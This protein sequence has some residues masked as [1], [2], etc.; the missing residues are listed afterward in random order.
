ML[1][2]ALLWF[3]GPAHGQTTQ[4]RGVLAL[5][6]GE[7][8]LLQLDRN[9]ANVLIANPSVADIQVVSPRSLFVFGRRL[10]QTTLSALDIG[11]GVAAQIVLR[12]TRSAAAA[13][14][15]LPRSN[16]TVALG[17][18]GDR[19]VARGTVG[20]LG[21]A[22]DTNATGRAYNPGG[23]PLLDR[24]RLA[25]AQ[26]VTLRVRI[27]EASRSVLNRLGVNLNVLANPGS[28]AFRL[29]T[30]GFVGGSTGTVTGIT[31]LNANLAGQNV[32]SPFG[33]L[34]G[35]VVTGRVNANALLDV[36]QSEGLVTSLAEPNLTTI[37]GETARF[38]VG[39]E[40]P[41]PVPQSFG[42]TTIEYKKY[43]VSLAFTPVLLPGERIAMR[44][45]PEVSELSNANSIAINGVS[46]PSFISRSAETNVEMASGQTLAIAGLFQRSEQT[47][48]SRFPFLGDIPILGALFRSSSFQRD[49][50]ELIIL[51]TPYL[52]EPVSAPRSFPLP[53]DRLG[54]SSLPA[55]ARGGFVID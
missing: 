45:Q 38:N 16:G 48:L 40:V 26:Q 43:G 12:V 24:T 19:I 18:E 5:S 23:L 8:R 6:V 4:A 35:G 13:Q 37:S 28:F 31:G 20:N 25:E 36:L 10:G 52:S 53:T 11:S 47:N 51:V 29:I 34:G 15:A 54:V 42:V 55:P 14:A 7:G 46:V 1:A 32:N 30:G 49:E 17:F 2:T 27:T 44:V 3:A 21:Q 33:Q 39:G 22:L 9:A 50:T 41:I